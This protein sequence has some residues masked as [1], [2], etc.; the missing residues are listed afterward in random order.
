[1]DNKQYEIELISLRQAKRGDYNA[2]DKIAKRIART[3][4]R[5]REERYIYEWRG[6]GLI[7][8]LERRLG[9]EVT[10]S[11][12]VANPEFSNYKVT[13]SDF[14]GILSKNPYRGPERIIDVNQ[15]L[16]P[17]ARLK[18]MRDYY[19]K[20]GANDPTTNGYFIEINARVTGFAG[21]WNGLISGTGDVCPEPEIEC[22]FVDY[23]YR[24]ALKEI[25][26]EV[27]RRSDSIKKEMGP[28]VGDL[29]VGSQEG[30][31]KQ[32]DETV[33]AIKIIKD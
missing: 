31:F 2:L 1:M 16:L 9:C 23:P 25:E 30:L 21:I 15:A 24:G 5:P 12:S 13:A 10:R 29:P 11:N 26:K 17:K 19:L 8:D 20:R 22:F 33:K 4:L 18:F 7:E 27:L 28:F 32:I 6:F 14:S 3:P